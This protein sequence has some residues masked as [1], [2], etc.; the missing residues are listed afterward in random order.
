MTGSISPDLPTF[1]PGL[2]LSQA[3]YTEAVRPILDWR[4]P[5]L[6]HSAARIDS[7]S[8]VLSFD[9]PRSM[10]HDWGP[11]LTLYLSEP[12]YQRYHAIISDALAI[13]LPREVHGFPTSFDATDGDPETSVRTRVLAWT[14]SGPVSHG[15]TIT[16]ASRFFVDYLGFDPTSAEPGIQ[17]WLTTPAQLLRTIRAGRVYWDGLAEID[18]ARA[19][20]RWYPNDIWRY[21][22]ACQWL[23]IDQE[24]PFVGRC[25]EL[26]DE[27]GS[28]LIAAR[29]AQEVIRLACLQEREYIPYSKWVGAAL[30]RLA[31]ARALQPPLAAALAA[32]SWQEREAALSEAYRLVG[33][34]QNEL[35]LTR[36]VSPSVVPFHDRPYLVPP[37]G[38]FAL[39]LRESIQSSAVRRLPLVSAVGQFADSTDVQTHPSRCRALLPIFDH[40]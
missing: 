37:A 7:G 17:D 27:L 34:C 22:L 26:G 18:P 11:R 40:D 1:V 3:F 31:S 23:R 35:R 36:S 14:A 15:V 28:R 5:G 2:Q 10:D 33:Q 29:Q 20:L 13:N 6:A 39:A 16:T 24:A 38:E 32:A 9:T 4:F 25:G 19:R 12:N 21:M 8:D 30:A